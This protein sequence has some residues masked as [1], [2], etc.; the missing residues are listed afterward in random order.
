TIAMRL[1]RR[2]RRHSPTPAAAPAPAQTTDTPQATNSR[3]PERPGVDS[4]WVDR[5]AP[6]RSW[7][8]VAATCAVLVAAIASVGLAQT[9]AGHTVLR[10]AGLAEQA[11]PFTEL[12][13]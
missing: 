11:R 1:P 8:G 13:F 6:R 2:K 4:E 7:F 12:Y 10:R 3:E 9:S 5:G